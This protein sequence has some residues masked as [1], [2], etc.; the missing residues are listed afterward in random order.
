MAYGFEIMSLVEV[1]LPSP[2][3]IRFHEISNDEIMRYNLD[4]LK[5]MRDDSHARLA[6]YQQKMV[7]YYNA[8]VR[9]RSF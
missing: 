8:K 2:H 6:S 3:L 4:F 5:E 7:R 9:K 1:G